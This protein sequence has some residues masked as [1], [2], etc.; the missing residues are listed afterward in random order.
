M[1]APAPVPPLPA[2]PPQGI[3]YKKPLP[4][5]LQQ[6]IDHDKKTRSGTPLSEFNR[7]GVLRSG[8]KKRKTRKRRRG[9]ALFDFLKK[10]DV[11]K[12]LP[13]LPS[14][15]NDY[16]TTKVVPGT[17]YSRP[18]AVPFSQ[19]TLDAARMRAMQKATLPVMP[20][21]EQDKLDNPYLAGRKKRS[22]RRRRH[23]KRR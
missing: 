1:S 10:P 6:L 20:I 7:T 19:Q 23:T 9:G 2:P 12:P 15:E 14:F 18:N 11:G 5:K 16:G 21:T 4:P 3:R 22:T 13:A 8:R 17:V